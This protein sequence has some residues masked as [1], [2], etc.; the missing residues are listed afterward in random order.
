MRKTFIRIITIIIAYCGVLI[1]SEQNA[2][3]LFCGE[4][5]E[6]NW[7]L[8]QEIE[9]REERIAKYLSQISDLQRQIETISVYL[10]EVRKQKQVAENSLSESQIAV[11]QLTEQLNMLKNHGS[12]IEGR[13]IDTQSQLADVEKQLRQ[14]KEQ[15]QLYQKQSEEAKAQFQE[16][17]TQFN[18]SQNRLNVVIR[19]KENAQQMAFEAQKQFYISLAVAIVGAIS[20]LLTGIGI[21]T[22]ARH[23]SKTQQRQREGSA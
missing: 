23:D 20:M 9:I 13:L 1:I 7:R 6:E 12:D 2:Y 10:E 5:E 22:K 15:K 11:G 4:C 14:E 21:G 3:S 16:M 8:N 18:Q 17:Q 19:E